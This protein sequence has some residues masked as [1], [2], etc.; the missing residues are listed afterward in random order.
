[1]ELHD[2]SVATHLFRIAQEA[3]S[4]AMHHGGAD[5][6]LIELA[7]GPQSST[8]AIRD[9]GVGFAVDGTVDHSGMGLRI[10]RHRAAMFGGSLGIERTSGHTIVTCV[11]PMTPARQQDEIARLRR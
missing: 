6:I 4:N 1:M 7:V 11:F 3:V 5:E 8:L 2:V 9:N 10:M